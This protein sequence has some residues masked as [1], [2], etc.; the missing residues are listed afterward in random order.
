MG[1]NYEYN[2]ETA[3]AYKDI[4]INGTTYEP[5]FIIDAL[6]TTDAQHIVTPA[7]WLP[8]SPVIVP[9][10][11]T[12]AELKD[13]VTNPHGYTCMDWYLCMKPDILN[14]EE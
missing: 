11:K 6:K 13:R 9:P 7:N 5:S 1:K 2:P 8:G 12:Y 10:P 4:G 14:E 3:K